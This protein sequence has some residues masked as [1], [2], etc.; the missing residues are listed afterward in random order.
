MNPDPTSLD[1]LHDIVAPPPVPLWPPAPGWYYVLVLFLVLVL[2]VAFRAFARW[3][4]N[5]YRREALAEFHRQQH[6]LADPA[7]RLAALAAMSVLLKRTAIT[8]YSRAAVAALTGNDWC[9]FLD[10]TGGTA[11]FSASAGRKLAAATYNPAGIAD[12]GNGEATLV[13]NAVSHWI[14]HHQTDF[15]QKDAKTAKEYET[16]SL[17]RPS[18][19]SVQ[20]V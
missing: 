12:L 18:R 16:G 8:A 3:Q 17:S 2:V 11:A 6:R 20:K 5:R 4:R 19:A 14:K 7:T 9:A 1:R 13:A 10:R 15:E